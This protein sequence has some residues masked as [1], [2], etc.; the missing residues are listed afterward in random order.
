MSVPE[1]FVDDEHPLHAGGCASC[2]PRGRVPSQERPSLSLAPLQGK[3]RELSEEAG[4]CTHA[5]RWTPETEYSPVGPKKL[6]VWHERAWAYRVDVHCAMSDSAG[7]DLCLA[8]PERTQTWVVSPVA[9][10]PSNLEIGT[11]TTGRSGTPARRCGWYSERPPRACSVLRE[12]SAPTVS[13]SAPLVPE[14][15]TVR[16]SGRW[17]C[18]R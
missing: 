16:E 2:S 6:K 3:G 9:G 1:I 4:H 15:R 14:V 12:K 13:A 8:R 10:G 18:K 17:Q 11:C 5:I 7:A